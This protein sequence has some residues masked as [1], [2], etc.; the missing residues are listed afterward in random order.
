MNQTTNNRL[1]KL[2]GALLPKPPE[3]VI[4]VQWANDLPDPIKREPGVIY[5]E[6][7]D[8]GT[9]GPDNGK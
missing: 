5:L 3:V 9:G 6:W 4:T 8:I 2:E 7:P 1:N